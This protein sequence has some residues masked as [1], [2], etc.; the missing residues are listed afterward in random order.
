MD[1][2]SDDYSYY[3]IF[4][5][6]SDDAS[7]TDGFSDRRSRDDYYGGDGAQDRA[8]VGK[9]LYVSR[10]CWPSVEVASTRWPPR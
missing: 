9:N 2:D 7:S 8:E 10:F 1:D 6:D 4:I 5:V 3:G